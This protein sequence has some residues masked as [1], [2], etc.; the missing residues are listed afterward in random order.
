MPGQPAA[1]LHDPIAHTNAHARFWAKF[2]GGLIGGIAVG[3]AAGVAVAAVVGTGGLAGP[4]VAGAVVVG[5]R[6][7]GGYVGASLGESIADA[8]VPETLTV[9]GAITSASSDVFVN[10]KA[11]GAARASPDIPMDTVS[12]SRD[13]PQ[14][15]LAEG[16]ETVFINHGVASRKDD[17]TECG[18]KVSEGSPNVFI[19]GPTARVREVADEVPLISRIAVTVFNLVMIY[20]GLRCLPKLARQGRKAL[21]CLIE[22]AIGVGMGIHGLVSSFGNP[23]HAATG[24]KFLGGEAELD[25]RLPGALPIEWQ[26][27]YS[28]HDL[29]RDG[30]LGQGWNLPYGSQL[31]LDVGATGEPVVVL[32]DTQGREVE[33]PDLEP[34]S[35]QLCLREGLDLCRSEG[36]HYF[37]H[38]PS[39]L[40]YLFEPPADAARNGQLLK[41][42]RVEDRNGNFIDLRHDALGRLVAMTDGTGRLL[43]LEYTGESPRLDAVRIAVGAP[44]ESP[45]LLVRYRHDDH[46]R[47]AE[48]TDR[49]GVVARRFAYDAQGL[50]CLHADAVGR[51][52]RYEW[53]GTGAEARVAR[54]WT[55]DGER[56]EVRYLRL[57]P[58]DAP[59]LDDPGVAVG[60]THVADQL[61]RGFTWQWNDEHQILG[62]TNAE[63]QYW[64]ARYNA[65][66]QLVAIT[67]PDGAT[68]RCDY[69]AQGFPSSR[70]D[71]LGRT[72]GTGWTDF[73]LPWRETEAD[74]SA[75]VY[76][77][78]DEGNLVRETDPLGRTRSYSHDRRGLPILVTDAHGGHNRLRWNERAL[79]VAFTDCSGKTTRYDYDGWGHLK[80]VT[81]AAGQQTRLTHDAMGRLLAVSLPD[82]S[83]QGFERD[84]AGRLV[85]ATDALSRATRFALDARGEPLWRQDAEG[86]RV[87]WQ[88][89]SAGRL[90]ALVNENGL[91]FEFV[92]DRADRIVEERR[93]GGTRV[94][95]A[96]DANGRPVT[97]THFPGIGDDDLKP[98]DAG[99]RGEAPPQGA[100]PLRTEF[101]R[102]AVGRLIEKRTASHHYRYRYDL[103]DRLVEALK[104]EV[105]GTGDAIELQPL[106]RTRF[107]Y[108]L[109]GQLTSETAIDERTGE[110]H[111]L[112]HEHDALGNRTRT[113]LP[114]LAG[115]RDTV[116]AF[117]Y[118]HYGSGHLHQVNVSRQH[119]D[120]PALH[121]LVSDIERDDLHR[122]IARSQGALSTRFALDPL[123]RRAAA[124]CRP[125]SLAAAFT[126]NDPA[127]RQALERA[128]TPEA[129][130]LD[131]LAKDYGYDPVG[132][133][134]RGR[135][136]LQG[137]FAHRYDTT[138]RIEESVRVP[139]GTSAQAPRGA[140]SH[141][142][143]AYDPAGN[144]LDASLANEAAQG[145]VGGRVHDNLVR[146]FEDKRYS[147]DG[148]GRLVRKRAGRHTEQ[149]FEWDDESRL[150]AVRTTRRPGTEHATTQTTRFDY[151]ALGR[152]VARHDAFG[153]TRFIWEGMQLIEERRGAQV[154]SYVYEPGSH[155][156]MARVEERS[157]ASNGEGGDTDRASRCEICHF[158]TTQAGLPEE[159]SGPDGTLR[160]R[161][162]YRTWGATVSEHWEASTLD[163]RPVLRAAA[164]GDEGHASLA[165]QNLRFPGQY[166]DRDT[167]LHYNTFRFYDPDI[168]RF[169][170]PDPIGLAGGANL[171]LYAPNPVS[172]IDPWGWSCGDQKINWKSVKQFG[173][174]FSRHGAGAKI[175][176]QLTD[177][178]RGTG[179]SQGQWRD[180]A[181]AAELLSGVKATEPTRIAIPEGMGQVI[182]PD[183]SV[184]PA[185]WAMVVPWGDAI[186][187]A[188]PVE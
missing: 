1:R 57:R 117:N 4:L 20:K 93:V 171:H 112:R 127:W 120:A 169:I 56:H 22:G 130:A 70:T 82:G 60:E 119:G 83:H 69:D 88:R 23:V 81:D 41:L 85:G 87:A 146:V 142:R 40:F 154:L 126:P 73:G 38:V 58:D 66:R 7:A 18:A 107:A 115:D 12:C 68:T 10:S 187:T 62:Y 9:T 94:R 176:K 138:S 111:E 157:P 11:V 35:R 185:Q 77:Y 8:L 31:R 158:H 89:D 30:A 21:P 159:L 133:L 6:M 53:T 36:G 123:G 173:H 32:I 168:G 50:M 84:A 74:G 174:A 76:A 137:A 45:G 59:P 102:D 161:A 188:F 109:L 116:R 91:R 164:H 17:H 24:G 148:H 184:V 86:R 34:G 166:L 100:Q 61:G 172:W 131:G 52:C 33:L 149:H 72:R 135:H 110:Q 147:Y 37:I 71:A 25:F 122:E 95:I 3:F 90:Q 108:D 42:A 92:R 104:L 152:R 98:R 97:I 165:E 180:N 156:P 105:T 151:D 141:E 125:S 2:A 162:S 51:E 55:S 182:R 113:E 179:Q 134:R 101:V 153:S 140:A 139:L 65:L 13:S 124:W 175:A 16:A 183:G 143:F 15:L 48:V 186:R 49:N 54:H 170:S 163:G 99:A 39:G 167:G 178:A 160:W 177:R 103:R 114:A 129:G 136:S 121:Q 5:A 29:R 132:E 75:H 181:A 96:Y 44:G 28:S 64:R 63:G 150:V 67:E 128:G 19:G 144:L 43:A 80:T 79:L 106:H 78:S 118:L 26:R 46:G 145:A 47:L 155:A 14:I 27:F